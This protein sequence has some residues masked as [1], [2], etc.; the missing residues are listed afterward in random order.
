MQIVYFVDKSDEEPNNF[1]SFL[2]K[3]IDEIS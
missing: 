1:M 3:L 2:M